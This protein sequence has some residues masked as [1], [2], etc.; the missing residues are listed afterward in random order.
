MTYPATVPASVCRPVPPRWLTLVL[1]VAGGLAMSAAFPDRDLWGLAFVGI[2]ALYLALLRPGIAWSALVG[3]VWGTS[4]FLVHVVWVQYVVG[5]VPW[6]AFSIAEGAFLALLGALWAVARRLPWLARAGW[7][8]AAAFPV[9]FTAT[10]VLRS[11]APWGGFP[12][13]RVAYGIVD[14]PLVRLAPL[15]GAVLVTFVAVVVGT[16]LA[17]VVLRVLAGR[18]LA[19]AGWVLVALTALV[20]PLSV[21]SD[22]RPQAGELRVGVVQ[23]NVSRPGLDAFDNA[24]EVLRNHLAGTEALLRTTSRGDL[25]MVLWPENGSDADPQVDTA[26]GAAIDTAAS[27]VGAPILVGAQEY[28]ATGGRYNVSLLWEPGRGVVDRYAKQHPVPFAEYIPIRSFV[29]H[30][31]SAVD[32]VTNDM[33]AGD[34]PAIM[35]VASERLGRDVPF[36]P[37]ICFEVAY[38][39]LVSQGVRLGGQVVVVQTNNASFGPTAE[40]TQ[41]LAISRFRAIETNRATVQVSTVGVSGVIAPNGVVLQRTGLFEPAQMV[42]SLP[43]RTDIT[44][45]VRLG[46]IPAWVVCGIGALLVLGAII[47]GRSDRLDVRTRPRSRARTPARRQTSA[48]PTRRKEAS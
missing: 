14:S 25:D 44:P 32:L 28:P 43:L 16:L 17:L 29:R 47:R 22:V 23:G 9:L 36:V 45:A 18:T 15:G 37:V 19:A 42:A 48:R 27:D 11:A 38:D 8:D 46:W 20:A 1:A 3:L 24:G 4:F 40:S 5:D 6:I 12:W 26:V 2:A 34:Q 31:S 10:E 39:Q 7:A 35:H 13:G 41:Q 33:I 21:P 30:F